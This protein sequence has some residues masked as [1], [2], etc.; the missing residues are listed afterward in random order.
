MISA[1]RN[2]VFPVTFA[3]HG[4]RV[5]FSI[6]LSHTGGVFSTADRLLFDLFCI[7]A[8]E[9]RKKLKWYLSIW[10]IHLRLLKCLQGEKVETVDRLDAL[11][12]LLSRLFCLCKDG[13]QLARVFWQWDHLGLQIRCGRM[14]SFW[15]PTFSELP[16]GDCPSKPA[17]LRKQVILP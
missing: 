6:S 12:I 7:L 10:L 1:S 14:R 3:S 2:P 15:V 16:S 9:K 4:Q 5:I 13:R 11:S 17:P 8:V